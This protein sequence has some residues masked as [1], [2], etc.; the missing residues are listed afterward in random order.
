MLRRL[1]AR[2]RATL[3]PPVLARVRQLALGWGQVTAPARMTPSFLIIGAQ[4]CGTTSLFRVLSE[5]PDL[6][7]PT[8]SKGIAYFDMNYP[9]G[10]RWYR[11]HFPVAALAR[12]RAGG[13]PQTFESSGY[14][15]VHPLAAGRIARDLPDVK[16]VLMV[17]NPVD[18]A[19]SAHRHES[20][21]GFEDVPF[22]RA[23]EL[24]PTRIAGEAERMVAD[25]TY[26]SFE[27]RHH[28][29]LTRSRYAE[30]V[31]RFVDALG[32]DRVRV[33]DADRF[34]ADPQPELT[35][36]F[37]WLGL[38]PWPVEHVDVWNARPGSPLDAELEER[39]M[40][41]FEEPD[42]RLA[43]LMGRLPSWRDPAFTAGR[44][45]VSR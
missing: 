33:V 4:R 12:W 27:H 29:Y 44:S 24:E 23:L 43:E 14:Y 32:P 21:R 6:V 39:L 13:R 45:P 26:E 17:R 20:S 16:V 10:E 28:A 25:P 8:M 42:R 2:A 15:S 22:E 35:A 36:L 3:P 38:R 7:R 9:K 37:A 41:Y 18:R 30:Q 5:H 40:R 19:Y 11:A 34:F 31:Q 1:T